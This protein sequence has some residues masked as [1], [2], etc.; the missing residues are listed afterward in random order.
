MSG[1]KKERVLR[2]THCSQR[3]NQVG[4]ATKT[5]VIYSD[6]K[7]LVLIN[8]CGKY[9]IFLTSNQFIYIKEIKSEKE[10]FFVCFYFINISNQ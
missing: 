2:A 3:S 4:D 7:Q 5:I 1:Y 9:A 8:I 10:L 6:C